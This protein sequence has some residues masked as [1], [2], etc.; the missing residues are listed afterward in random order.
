MSLVELGSI[1]VES[2]IIGGTLFIGDLLMRPNIGSPMGNVLRGSVLAMIV[3]YVY[4][5]TT[6]MPVQRNSKTI[7]EVFIAFIMITLTDLV[8]RPM[9]VAGPG[10][11]L[12]EYYLQGL[13]VVSTLHFVVRNNMMD[14]GSN[15]GNDNGDESGE[16]D[17][18]AN[19][20]DFH[21]GYY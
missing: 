21:M 10:V 7:M 11:E 6:A 2:V 17:G 14:D 18:S 3:T 9:V 13:I 1:L 8:M 19:T 4:N 20:T 16:D 15:G 5:S 12:V